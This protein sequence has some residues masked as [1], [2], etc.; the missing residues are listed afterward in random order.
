[1]TSPAPLSLE[2]TLS[3]AW[4]GAALGAGV[5][6]VETVE[7]I[8]TVATK[9]RFRVELETGE[10]R[11]YCVKGLFGEGPLSAGHARIAQAE[12]RFYRD[13]APVPGVHTPRCRYS[14]IDPAS[15]HG[16]IV[17]DDVVAAGGRFLTALEPYSPEQ[18]RRSLG[19]IATLH[20]AHWQGAGLDRHSWLRNRLVE[21]ADS[22]LRTDAELQ[23]L[24][25]DPRGEQLPGAIKD[26]GRIMRALRALASTA[27][28]RADALVHGDAH[29]G[30]LFVLDGA[31]SIIDWQLLQRA[32]WGLDVA[33]HICSVL[34]VDNRRESERDLLD[35][36]LD[37][38]AAGGV[39]PPGR[40]EAW[41][42][43]R[44]SVA[45]G[46]Y[47]WSVTRRV[48]PPVIREF[49]TRL[50]TAVTDLETFELL[51]V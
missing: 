18:A 50:G 32:N 45:Y 46:Y 24:V 29:A 38:L 6:A 47:L 39:T 25:D 15:G 44:S 2:E 20:A 48:D 1:M 3:P 26:A 23:A 17:M 31:T 43:Y 49:C 9:T 36:Y 21:L 27:G 14:G 37:R 19:Q 12:A 40:E 7:T 13:F 11:H 34:S 16:I 30:N 4:L 28:A 42:V 8:K 33:Y 5:R 51:G 35:H 10:H 22:P 41:E